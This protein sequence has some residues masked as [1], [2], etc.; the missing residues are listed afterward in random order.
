MWGRAVRCGKLWR[1]GTRSESRRQRSGI[2]D[3]ELRRLPR[4]L[5]PNAWSTL[6]AQAQ[7]MWRAC[8]A[9]HQHVVWDCWMFVSRTRCS[10]TRFVP[11]VAGNFTQP[12]FMYSHRCVCELPCHSSNEVFQCQVEILHVASIDKWCQNSCRVLA[13]RTCHYGTLRSDL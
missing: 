6:R 2:C 11:C 13:L 8:S 1:G 9:S 10:T 7:G 12:C 4:L 5:P 3:L